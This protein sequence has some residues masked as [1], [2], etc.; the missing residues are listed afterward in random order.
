MAI[1]GVIVGNMFEDSEYE[2]PVTAFKNSGHS[3]VNIGLA[4]G[5]N[6][7]GKTSGTTVSIDTSCN[8][9]AV[10]S[11][12]ALLIPGG[13]SPDNLRAHEDAVLFVKQFFESGKPV[14]AICHGPQLLISACVLKGRTLT[15]WKSI[16]QDIRNAGA[17]YV[18]KDVVVD[19]K[20]V[21]SRCPEDLPV[22]IKAARDCLPKAK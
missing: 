21:S 16:A 7:T 3:I 20:L 4:A 1:I 18:D 13:Y 17:T 12:D 8:N 9:M 10:N 15:G 14:F 6:V 19:G 5:L 11:I 2:Q 22:F